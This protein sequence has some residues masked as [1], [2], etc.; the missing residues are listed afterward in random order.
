MDIVRICFVFVLHLISFEVRIR[1]VY[2]CF[3]RCSLL[4]LTIQN[5]MR[6]SFLSLLAI[7]RL[8]QTFLDEIIFPKMRLDIYLRFP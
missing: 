4:I 2:L 5:H 1:Q 8:F 3:L 7:G 6:F